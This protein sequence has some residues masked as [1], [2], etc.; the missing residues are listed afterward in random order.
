MVF[1]PCKEGRSHTPDEW[2]KADAVADGTRV[3]LEA[4]LRVDAPGD[5][6][7]RAPRGALS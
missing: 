3:L 7:D 1:I 5:A 4:I 2:A 6:N